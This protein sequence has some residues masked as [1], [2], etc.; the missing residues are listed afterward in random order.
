MTCNQVISVIA[1]SEVSQYSVIIDEAGGKEL[2]DA[3]TDLSMAR[4]WLQI[5]KLERGVSIQITN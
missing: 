5:I 4:G 3:L 2:H 1:A